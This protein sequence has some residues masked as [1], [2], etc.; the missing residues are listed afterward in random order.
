MSRH[1][2]EPG[3]DYNFILIG[4][5]SH[6]RDYKFCHALNQTLQIELKKL[7]DLQIEDS[8]SHKSSD[9]PVFTYHDD[10]GTQY[11]LVGNHGSNGMLLP[12]HEK[13]DYFTIIRDADPSFNIKEIVK[14]IKD[15][16]VTVMCLQIEPSK[17]KSKQNLIFDI[18]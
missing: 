14:R 5:A 12:E 7:N 15:M 11:I 18:G 10:Y 4:I 17:L 16:E 13:L 3:F 8:K 2:L 6:A 1:K 9:F